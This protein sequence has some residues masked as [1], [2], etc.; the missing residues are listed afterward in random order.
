GRAAFWPSNTTR[1]TPR[2]GWWGRT[3]G[4]IVTHPAATLALGLV[5]FGA[6]ASA[7]IG[8]TP[9]GFGSTP[10]AARGSASPARHPLLPPPF[11]AASGNPTVVLLR[12]P[13]PAWGDP[14]R[15]ARAEQ[16]LAAIPQFRGLTG[17]LDVN[18]V[19]VTPGRLADL[20]A[21]L[22]DPSALPAQPSPG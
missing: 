19:T 11:P 12:F 16:R 20:H 13:A 7:A 6:L 18:G 15:V 21:T 4:R 9:A 22:G 14:A 8:Y 10:P 17:P 2:L 1:G 5:F 3:A